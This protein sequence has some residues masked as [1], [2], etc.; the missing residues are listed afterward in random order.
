MVT[1]E[2]LTGSGRTAGKAD[3]SQY[4]VLHEDGKRLIAG[5]FERAWEAR[6]CEPEESF[7]PFIFAFIALN[8][9][10]SCITGCDRDAQWRNA[11]ALDP[12]VGG[13]FSR[14]AADPSSSVSAPARE[15]QR[16]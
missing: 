11:L 1:C 8:A 14:L 6:D 3:L 15:F 10:A 7:E 13:D 16:L 4:G 5:W 2:E 12:V 9:W